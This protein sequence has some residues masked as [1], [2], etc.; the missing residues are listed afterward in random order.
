MKF[1]TIEKISSPE[2]RKIRL[3]LAG[4]ILFSIFSAIFYPYD[5]L[6]KFFPEY[7]RNESTCIM[8]NIFGIPC[9]FCGMS[10]AFYEFI[11]FNFKKSIYY[12]PSSVIFFSFSAIICLSIFVLSL[13]NYKISVSFSRKSLI[14][15]GIVLIVFWV[16]N[17]FFGH[18]S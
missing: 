11:N 15:S 1:L 4:F 8:L 16:L 9:P 17:I 2:A 10:H 7:F 3:I 13:F 6:M 5:I 18:L 14:I 12:N